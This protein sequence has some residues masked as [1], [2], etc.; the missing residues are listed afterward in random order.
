MLFTDVHPNLTYFG[1]FGSNQWFLIW[2]N[3]Y[4]LAQP[5][6]SWHILTL[7]TLWTLH[8]PKPKSLVPTLILVPMSLCGESHRSFAKPHFSEPLCSM[9]IMLCLESS[10]FS[11]NLCWLKDVHHYPL[12]SLL[13]V[14]G[15][16]DWLLRTSTHIHVVYNSTVFVVQFSSVFRF[17]KSFRACHTDGKTKLP[18]WWLVVI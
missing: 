15:M 14:P 11:V 9:L 10:I 4:V 2:A 16:V 8:V 12:N 1:C 5:M 7:R 17:G 6:V 3:Y 18:P 13:L